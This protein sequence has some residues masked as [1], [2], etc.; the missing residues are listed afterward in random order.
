LI[1]TAPLAE[2]YIGGRDISARI[3][4]DE[5]KPVMDP[6]DP[7]N[8]LIIM[9]GPLTGTLAPSSGRTHFRGVS[10]Q[11]YPKPWYTR[12]NIG[13]RFGSEL[14]YARYEEIIMRKMQQTNLPVDI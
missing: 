12:S 13:G 3:P 2:K 5:T 7:A 14:K 1:D 11:T 10:P 9:T 8:L 6:Y 4:W